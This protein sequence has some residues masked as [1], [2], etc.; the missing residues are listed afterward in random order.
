M[1]QASNKINQYLGAKTYQAICEKQS[2]QNQPNSVMTAKTIEDENPRGFISLIHQEDILP[3]TVADIMLV[4]IL[5]RLENMRDI[6]MRAANLP[7]SREERAACQTEIDRLKDEINSFSQAISEMR[8]GNRQL[9]NEEIECNVEHID[10][11]IMRI[12]EMV[13]EW[14]EHGGTGDGEEKAA[15][16]M[17]ALMGR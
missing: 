17:N 5:K 16:W 8:A 1:R 6:T 10:Q 4:E 7:L 2:V 12:S 13:E 11:S 15:A 14:E 9:S 3:R